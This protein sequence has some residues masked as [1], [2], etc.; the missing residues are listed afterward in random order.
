MGYGLRVTGYG[1]QTA[2]ETVQSIGIANGNAGN[3]AVALH[4]GP[5]AVTHAIPCR[6]IMDLQDG[7]TQRAYIVYQLVITAV[8]TI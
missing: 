2:Q 5:T 3:A 6:Y 8:Y 1:L 4:N 7:G